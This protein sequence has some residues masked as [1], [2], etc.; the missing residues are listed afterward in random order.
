MYK[1]SFGKLNF[2]LLQN[3][4]MRTYKKNKKTILYYLKI[5]KF[6]PIFLVKRLV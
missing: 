4:H 2:T 5:T 1:N 3:I 6:I